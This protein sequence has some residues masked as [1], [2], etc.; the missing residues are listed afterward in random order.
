MILRHWREVVLYVCAALA[1]AVALSVKLEESQY[2]ALL[3]GLTPLEVPLSTP[4]QAGFRA[5]FTAVWTERHWVALQFPANS[6]DLNI[7]LVLKRAEDTIGRVRDEQPKFDF[8]WRVLEG[9]TVIGRGSG[10]Q[11]PTGWFGGSGT[12]GFEFGDFPAKAGH[13]YVLEASFGPDFERFLRAGPS[14]QIGVA[15]ATASV[16]LALGHSLAPAVQYSFVVVGLIFLGCA[17]MVSRKSRKS[18]S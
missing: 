14:I 5:P 3:A 7:D 15:A 8:Q 6:G 18:W 13:M 2:P 11:R 16:G 9:S 10:D 1:L 12:R 4:P 17:V